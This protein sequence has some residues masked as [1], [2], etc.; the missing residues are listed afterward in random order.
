MEK[1]YQKDMRHTTWDK[2]F[3]R[4]SC[5]VALLEQWL[6]DLEISPGTRVL[7][8]G[9]GPGYF[10]LMLAERVGPAGVVYA[11]DRS[12]EALAYLE[13]LQQERGITNIQR[14]VADITTLPTGVIHPQAALITMVLHHAADPPGMVAG[15]AR[16][17]SMGSR[18]IVAEFHPEGPGEYGPPLSERVHP[19]Q[20][21][22]WCEEAGFEVLAYRRQTPEHYMLFK[23]TG[24]SR[25]PCP[26]YRKDRGA[27]SESGVHR[28]ATAVSRPTFRFRSD[29]GRISVAVMPKSS[30]MGRRDRAHPGR[31]R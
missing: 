25:G 18:A 3:E 19:E 8:V 20:V 30:P 29:N 2:V 5:R 23:N 24:H 28:A 26:L 16:Q 22:A 1:P 15:A 12:A 21:R 11:V 10:S 31:A 9:A 17:L 27:R 4:Q 6:M 13:R 14:I 7:D